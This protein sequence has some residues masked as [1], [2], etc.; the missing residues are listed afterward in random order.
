ML[1]T[2]TQHFTKLT[3]QHSNFWQKIRHVFCCQL[4]EV[5]VVSDNTK[6]TLH[7][8]TQHKSQ[9]GTLY[10]R[11]GFAAC[12]HYFPVCYIKNIL[13]V[14]T[15]LASSS[16]NMFCYKG[17]SELLRFQTEAIFVLCCFVLTVLLSLTTQHF[18]HLTTK[19]ITDFFA[20]S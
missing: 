14:E 15:C 20:K 7:K 10:S 13:C 1:S 3:T 16:I 8:T 12:P 9:N 17:G 4:C 5:C 19:H 6:N 11:L 18:T 2:T